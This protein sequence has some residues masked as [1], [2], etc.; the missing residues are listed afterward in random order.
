M[1][2]QMLITIKATLIIKLV[3]FMIKVPVMFWMRKNKSIIHVKVAYFKCWFIFHQSAQTNVLKCQNTF[4]T[5]LNHGA[6]ALLR[7][8]QTTANQVAVSF[9]QMF[10]DTVCLLEKHSDEAATGRN[11]AT[12]SYN[13][14]RTVAQLLLSKQLGDELPALYVTNFTYALPAYNI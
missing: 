8:F 6:H 2:Q 13:L 14:R 5:L 1:M 11:Y 7:E 12:V 9:S 3:T 4:N 10:T